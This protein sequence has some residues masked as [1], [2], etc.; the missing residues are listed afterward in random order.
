MNSAAAYDNELGMD[1]DDE[2]MDGDIVSL[3]IDN[4][5]LGKSAAQPA[6]SKPPPPP[7]PTTTTTSSSARS[8]HVFAKPAGIPISRVE[9]VIF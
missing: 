6:T 8:E 1:D 2:S 9:K 4:N 3:N 5:D 7:R